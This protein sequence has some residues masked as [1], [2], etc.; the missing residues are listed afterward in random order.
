MKKRKTN[1]RSKN[2][3]GYNNNEYH[4]HSL[5]FLFLVLLLFFSFLFQSVILSLSLLSF[6]FSIS[7][8]SYLMLYRKNVGFQGS[9]SCR[10]RLCCGESSVLSTNISF[11]YPSSVSQW[12]QLLVCAGLGTQR[13]SIVN[14]SRPY[15]RSLGDIRQSSGGSWALVSP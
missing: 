5:F 1:R 3:D 9:G 14:P 2:T 6:F 4:H 12:R 15:L 10:C 11:H 8:T 7:S 13:V